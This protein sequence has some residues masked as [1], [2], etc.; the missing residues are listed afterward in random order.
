MKKLAVAATFSVG[1]LGLVACNSDSSDSDSEVV[2][3][4]T[5]GEITKDDFYEELKDIAGES[6]LQ[7]LIF[8][9]VLADEYGDVS[10]EDID[11][12]IDEFKDQFG[13]QYPMWLQENGIQDDESASFRNQ[14]GFIVLQEKAQFEGIEVS[15]EDVEEKFEEMKENDEHEIKA[16]HILVE[17]QEEAEDIKKELDEDGDFAELAKEH[18]IDG[19]AENGGDLGFFTKEGMVPE[20]SDVAFTLDV[21]EISDPVESEHGYHII[22]VTEIADLEEMQDDIRLMMREQEAQENQEEISERIDGLIEDADIDIKIEE[23]EDIFELEEAPAPE[24]EG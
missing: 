3:E 10:D 17:D 24:M 22:K 14:V 20:F 11:D 9:Q 1:L 2:A 4:T 6:V 16:S 21:D 15:D 8:T 5:V 7:N 18:S 12:K 23:F 13:D 19:S